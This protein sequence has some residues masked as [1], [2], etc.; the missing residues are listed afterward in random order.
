MTRFTLA[1][2]CSGRTT[3][4]PLPAPATA[5]RRSDG[6]AS[7]AR[8]SE[9]RPAEA[10]P[11]KARR[12]RRWDGSEVLISSFPVQQLRTIEPV[13]ALVQGEQCPR[14]ILIF[15]HEEVRVK[16]RQDED[17]DAGLA[18]GCYQRGHH[19]DRR[20]VDRPDHLQAKPVSL[21]TYLLR[22]GGFGADDGQFLTSARD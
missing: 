12:V 5:P 8:A 13:P 7:A 2:R 9:P 11:R 3:P 4:R 15:H 21:A 17:A 10:R 22:H 6:S 18:Q 19:P 16:R 1:A 14:Q 20:E